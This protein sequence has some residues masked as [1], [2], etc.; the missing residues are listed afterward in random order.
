MTRQALVS[1][2]AAVFVVLSSV[3]QTD[4][5]ELRSNQNRM[6]RV[7]VGVFPLRGAG[8]TLLT[9]GPRAGT[10]CGSGT[11]ASIGHGKR[12]SLHTAAE[13]RD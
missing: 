1:M 13:R 10:Q 2:A 11:G 7:G 5:G 4:K 6:M 3:G 9:A 12:L 8:M